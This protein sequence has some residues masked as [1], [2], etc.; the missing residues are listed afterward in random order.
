[1]IRGQVFG[2]RFSTSYTHRLQ[3]PHRPSA[4][5]S[6]SGT[7]EAI[8]ALVE[9]MDDEDKSLQSV[10]FIAILKATAET[11]GPRAAGTDTP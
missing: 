5:L 1:V 3:T 2:V 10:A 9:A 11:S 4:G 6:S 7:K 8:P